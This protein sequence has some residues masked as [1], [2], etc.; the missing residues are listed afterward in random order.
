MRIRTLATI[1][2]AHIRLM[3]QD[4]AKVQRSTKNTVG[5]MAINDMIE[6]VVVVVVVVLI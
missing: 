2:T 6:V 1:Y 3:A 4:T 5:Y